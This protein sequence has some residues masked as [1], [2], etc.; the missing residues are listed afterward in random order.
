MIDFLKRR[1]ANESGHGLRAAI[2]LDAVL[3]FV[4]LAFLA[5]AVVGIVGILSRVVS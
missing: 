3:V 4:A 1:Y 2:I 5:N